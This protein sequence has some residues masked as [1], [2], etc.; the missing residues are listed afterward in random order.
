MPGDA[1]DQYIPV[2]I[3]QVVKVAQDHRRG[4][5]KQDP[6][7]HPDDFRCQSQGVLARQVRKLVASRIQIR[8]PL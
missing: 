2:A 4:I 8:K 1:A 6:T 7:V 5:R 3:K